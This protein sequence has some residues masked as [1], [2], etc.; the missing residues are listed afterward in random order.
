VCSRC[1]GELVEVYDNGKWS[2]RCTDHP[3]R[4]FIT[5]TWVEH[6]N[7]NAMEE[8]YSVSKNYP[9]LANIETVTVAQANELLF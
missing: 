5:R 9:Q 8:F 3:G 2:V 7:A 4:G 1:L 6:Y